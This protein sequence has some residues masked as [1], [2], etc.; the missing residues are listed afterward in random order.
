MIDLSAIVGFEWGANTELLTVQNGVSTAE[1][2]QVFFNT[3]L[4]LSDAAAHSH[5]HSHST[6]H[7]ETPVHAL[8]RTDEGRL[9]HITLTLRRAGELIR[10]VAAR[11]MHTQEQMF[12]AQAD[13]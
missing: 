11:D 12:Y 1:V 5:S 7:N 8:G 2:E 6:G 3:P 9:L 4:L 10:V 13:Q